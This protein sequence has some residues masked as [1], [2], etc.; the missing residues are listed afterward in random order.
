M[1]AAFVRETAYVSDRVLVPARPVFFALTRDTLPCFADYSL[2]GAVGDLTVLASL[3][4][5]PVPECS[6]SYGLTHKTKTLFAPEQMLG[7]TQTCIKIMREDDV[8]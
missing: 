7:C 3:T 4:L 5:F 1:V 6:S 2:T 8:A